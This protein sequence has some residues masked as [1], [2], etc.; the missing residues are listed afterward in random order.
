MLERLWGGDETLIVISTDLSHHHP[1]A[2]ARS[3]DAATAARIAALASDLDGEEACGCRG[4]NGLLELAR[5]RQLD[6]ERLD[7]RNSGDVAGDKDRVVGYGAWA[8]RP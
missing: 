6:C 1:Y 3:L 8:L 7:L 4:L 5:M 2:E